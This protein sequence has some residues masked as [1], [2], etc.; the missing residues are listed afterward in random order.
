[1]I[2]PIPY[3]TIAGKRIGTLN[4]KRRLLILLFVKPIKINNNP[5]NPNNIMTFNDANFNFA[6]KTKNLEIIITI[7]E[8]IEEVLNKL[9]NEVI[10]NEIN[11]K[12]EVTEEIY[13]NIY[14]GNNIEY[15]N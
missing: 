10:N 2:K 13:N 3:K 1:M 15:K 6:I 12:I 14:T 8:E 9:K 5:I 7:R 4:P 11:S